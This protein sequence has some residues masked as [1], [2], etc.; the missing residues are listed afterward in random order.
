MMYYV[1]LVIQSLIWKKF[2]L[3]EFAGL[4][5]QSYLLALEIA[6]NQIL[7]YASSLETELGRERG[8]YS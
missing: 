6:K 7:I 5:S 3:I 1:F 4:W 8:R 2:T